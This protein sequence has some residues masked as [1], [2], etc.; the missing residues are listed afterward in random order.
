MTIRRLAE[1]QRTEIED[2]ELACAKKGFSSADFDVA[3]DERY[4]VGNVGNIRRLVSVKRRGVASGAVFNAG[5]SSSWIVDF[6]NA[7]MAGRFE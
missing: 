6:E 1:L 4:S 5:S 3:V 7:L 2:F